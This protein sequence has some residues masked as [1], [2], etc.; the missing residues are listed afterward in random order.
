MPN[1]YKCAYTKNEMFSDAYPTKDVFNGFVFEV[2]TEIVEKEAMKFNMGD[3][4]DLDD[5]SSRVNNLV[6]GHLLVNAGFDKKTFQVW[7]K[8]YIGKITKQFKEDHKVEEGDQLLKDFKTNV[9]A[10]IKDA[11]DNF[12]EYE[13]YLGEDNDIEGCLGLSKWTDSKNDKGPKFY[14]IKQGLIKEKI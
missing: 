10:L 12:G 5:Q 1:L 11:L 4:D 13:F 7:A 14:F 3:C 2:E 8:G 9:T 6:D